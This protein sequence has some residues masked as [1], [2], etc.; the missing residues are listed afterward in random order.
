MVSSITWKVFSVPG[1]GELCRIDLV[2][3]LGTTTV[4]GSA[5][6][7]TPCR[8]DPDL[9][10]GEGRIFPTTFPLPSEMAADTLTDGENWSEFELFKVNATTYVLPATV[11][12]DFSTSCPE[13]CVH[14]ALLPKL[15]F[16]EVIENCDESAVCDPVSPDIVTFDPFARS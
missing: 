11:P 2:L 16:V 5:P 6:S 8:L 3:N 4:S 13:F 14:E 12:L 10:I 9:F 7:V 15:L 1:T